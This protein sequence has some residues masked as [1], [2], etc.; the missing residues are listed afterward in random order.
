MLHCTSLLGIEVN[1]IID[2]IKLVF[3]KAIEIAGRT[4]LSP[5]IARAAERA[6]DV[7]ISNFLAGRGKI[8]GEFQITAGI[9]A[10]KSYGIRGIA[11]AGFDINLYFGGV[12]SD[13]P[14]EGIKGQFKFSIDSL[15]GKIN[16]GHTEIEGQA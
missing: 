7:L 13:H 3:R 4:G 10:A 14:T 11:K 6:L 16:W 9:R 5:Y 1:K 2:F 8:I 12:L 15:R